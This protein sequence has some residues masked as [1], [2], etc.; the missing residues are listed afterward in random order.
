MPRT[1]KVILTNMC[2]I[3]DGQGQ[4]VMQIRDP[5]RYAWSGAALPGGHIEAGESL[6]EAVVRE[7]Y[8]ETGLVISHPHLVGMKHW[9]TKEGIRYLV[10]L[11]R[12]SDFTG[13]I[14]STEEGEIKWVSRKD[15]PKLDLAY[16]MLNLL[17]VFDEEELSELFYAKRLKDDFIREFW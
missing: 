1:E 2:L 5:E 7:V 3:E 16:D 9:H 6:H 4:I 12:T 13:E 8:E 14:R 10:F 15:L 17:R 11:Y